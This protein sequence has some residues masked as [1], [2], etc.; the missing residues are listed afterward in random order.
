VTWARST[1]FFQMRVLFAEC[2]VR[3]VAARL[4]ERV[5]IAERARLAG[6]GVLL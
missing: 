3:K 1:E 5:P 2:Y 6:S 4:A